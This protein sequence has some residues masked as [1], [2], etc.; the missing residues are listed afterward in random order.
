MGYEKKLIID[1][2]NAKDIK[3]KKNEETGGLIFGTYDE[4]GKAILQRVTQIRNSAKD[5]KHSYKLPNTFYCFLK[6]FR[7][8]LASKYLIGEWHSHPSNRLYPSQD[9]IRAMEKKTKKMR[10]GA[11]YLGIAG[12]DMNKDIIN[13]FEF[14]EKYGDNS[15]R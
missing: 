3:L 4:K 11:Y 9:D 8:L 6:S 7:Y 10:N 12:R 5:K 14:S 1:L 15:K 2:S 13:I